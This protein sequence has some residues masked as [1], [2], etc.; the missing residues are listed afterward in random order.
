[1]SSSS[2]EP[3][4]TLT[5]SAG[6]TSS[7]VASP[8]HSVVS[9]LKLRDMWIR[10]PNAAMLPH[11]ARTMA[12]V[13]LKT[14]GEPRLAVVCSAESHLND[15]VLVNSRSSVP[16]SSAD[17]TQMKMMDG[18][19]SLSPM[20][21]PKMCRSDSVCASTS[22]GVWVGATGA[23]AEDIIGEQGGAPGVEGELKGS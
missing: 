9:R 1:M 22:A 19:M 11:S 4:C 20:T 16:M 15:A 17:H 14:Q 23:A 5:M 3:R 10:M 13:G 12:Q 21:P 7:S 2:T 18:I 8:V 6:T